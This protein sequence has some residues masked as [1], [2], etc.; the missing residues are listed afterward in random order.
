M[1]EESSGKRCLCGHVEGQH[2]E[3]KYGGCQVYRCACGAFEPAE[4]PK[5]SG[6]E[7]VNRLREV[8]NSGK[9]ADA[10]DLRTV[11]DLLAASEAREQ[12]ES[13]IDWAL[14][15]LKNRL[16]DGL[17]NGLRYFGDSDQ[18]GHP[19]GYTAFNIPDWEARQLIDKIDA[20]MKEQA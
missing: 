19:H 13:R 17:Q 6:N 16:I 8:A 2:T 14:T 1:S 20:A 18:S 9:K 15:M 7:V 12:R 3:V 4:S 5:P 11:L 10:A